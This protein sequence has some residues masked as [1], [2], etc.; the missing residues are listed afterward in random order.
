MAIHIQNP[1]EAKPERISRLVTRIEQGDIKVPVFQRGFVWRQSQIIELLDS[2]YRGYPIGSLL[3]WLATEALATERD[4]AGFELP[5]TPEKYPRN[6]VLDGQQRLATIYAVLRFQGPPESESIYNVSYDLESQCFVQTSCPAPATHLPLNLLFETKRFLA[7]QNG[8]VQR[9]DGDKLIDASN[10]LL[11]TFREYAIPVVTVTEAA[12]EDVSSIF[13]RINS[14]GTKLTT[15]DLMVAATWSEQFDLR[16]EIDATLDELASSHFADLSPVSILQALAAHFVGGAS[17]KAIFAL[18]DVDAEE[19]TNGMLQLREAA[20]RAVDFLSTEVLVKSS[21]FLPYERQFVALTHVF[22]ERG[23]VAGQ[24]L[25]TLRRWFWRTSF[26]ERYRRGGEGL[27]DQD[28]GSVLAACDEPSRLDRFG[29][30]IAAHDFLSTE[31]RKTSAV[32]EA[33]AAVLGVQQPRNLMNGS[34]IDTNTALSAYNR[35]EFHHIFPKAFLR[36]FDVS[37]SQANSL[38]N[39]CMLA[40]EQNRAIGK[41]KPSDYFAKLRDELGDEWLDVLRSNL[42]PEEAIPLLEADDYFGFIDCRAAHLA[43]A[44]SALV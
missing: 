26:S 16:E 17:R 10:V 40:S 5:E 38:A 12:V 13:E 3:F 39:I 4:I 29:V 7:F 11:E 41:R 2:I 43:E 14:T 19:L 20:K 31:F 27:F 30:T 1:P 9:P 35:K 33:F 8:L 36:T 44:V 37:A 25:D 21:D 28:L 22:L 24:E 18:R 34:R 32:S 15:Y 42:I 23:Q 6:Y